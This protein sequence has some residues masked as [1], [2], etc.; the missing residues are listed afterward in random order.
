MAVAKLAKYDQS[1]TETLHLARVSKYD[2]FLGI[3]M[4]MNEFFYSLKI[5]KIRAIVMQSN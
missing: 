4:T 1:E 2:N 3:Y 5:S